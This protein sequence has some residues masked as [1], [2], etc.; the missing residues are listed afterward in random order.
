MDLGQLY[1]M[2][3]GAPWVLHKPSGVPDKVL[4]P[5]RANKLEEAVQG[6]LAC[7]IPP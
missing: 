5:M 6:L 7:L 3:I 1:H 2:Y 4:L